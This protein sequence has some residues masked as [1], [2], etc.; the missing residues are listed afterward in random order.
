MIERLAPA[1]APIWLTGAAPI[2]ANLTYGRQPGEIG[3][4]WKK[5]KIATFIFDTMLAGQ[6]AADY[7]VKF[8]EKI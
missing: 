8:S 2:S 6:A 5:V 1:L 7:N 3:Q 4:T